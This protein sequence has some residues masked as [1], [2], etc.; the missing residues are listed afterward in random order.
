MVVQAEGARGML[1]DDLER[2]DVAMGAIE[3]TGR[4]TLAEMRRL[5]GV[6]RHSNARGG[7]E[8]QPGVA[9]VY[10]LIE[11]ARERGQ[12]VE[13]HV[14]GEPGTLAAGVDLGLYRI[15]EDALES[16]RHHPAS[17]VAV[18]LRFRR[19]GPR[20]AAHRP[21][22]RTERMAHRR[23]ARADLTVRRRTRR[24]ATQQ[25]WLAARRPHAPRPAR[26]AHVTVH[27]VIADDQQLVRAG[28]RTVLAD[29]P[30][31]EVVG[32]ASNGAEAVVFAA[33]KLRPNVVLMDIR[34]PEVDG[35][36]A[37]R[38]IVSEHDDIPKTSVLILTT[39][40]L[41]EYVYDRAARRR[42]ERL[43]PEGG[44][45]SSAYCRECEWSTTKRCAT[46]RR[47]SHVA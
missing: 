41:D 3:D 11:R 30:D 35:I 44:H 32:E 4:Q 1:A 33:A 17:T 45:R 6:L 16:A 19:G 9:Q 14:D 39:F 42:G 23:D 31:I 10:S 37:T 8:P 18:T 12:P 7:R 25:G 34:M 26:S 43:P 13:L 15:L 5:L 46:T 38:Q 36:E 47:A 28:F 21:L 40:D 22:P 24:R 2:A 27:V 29:E 20:A